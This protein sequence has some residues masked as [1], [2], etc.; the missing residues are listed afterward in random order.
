ML[1]RFDE[2]L[3]RASNTK[4]CCRNHFRNM[5]RSACGQALMV[6][7]HENLVNMIFISFNSSYFS[8]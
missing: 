1:E 6:H 8:H 3:T 7:C 2:L 5:F 4:K